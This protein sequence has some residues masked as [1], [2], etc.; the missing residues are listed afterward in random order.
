MGKQANQHFCNKP[1]CV[2]PIARQDVFD[3]RDEPK[4]DPAIRGQSEKQADDDRTIVH[5]TH[6]PRPHVHC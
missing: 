1:E 2:P 5:Q 4:D 3:G 6:I